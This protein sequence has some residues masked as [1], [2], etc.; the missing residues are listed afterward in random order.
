MFVSDLH[1]VFGTFYDNK[2]DKVHLWQDLLQSLK[3]FSNNNED[4]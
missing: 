3:Q 4:H 2:A 1:W